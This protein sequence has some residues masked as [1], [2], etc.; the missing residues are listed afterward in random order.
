ML[1]KDFEFAFKKMIAKKQISSKEKYL[2]ASQ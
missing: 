1:K 2:R